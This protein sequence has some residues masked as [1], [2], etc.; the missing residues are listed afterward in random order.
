[1]VGI[2]STALHFGV[3]TKPW[4]S[5]FAAGTVGLL[6]VAGATDPSLH[7]LVHNPGEG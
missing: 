3:D 5:G 1:M 2:K 4:L 6:G 7:L